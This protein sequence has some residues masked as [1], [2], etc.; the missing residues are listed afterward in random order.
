MECR[1]NCA[2]DRSQGLCCLVAT[3]LWRRLGRTLLDG[4][5]G[6]G[7]AP[8]ELLDGQRLACGTLVARA[9]DEPEARAQ[10]AG[11]RIAGPVP[12]TSGF[13]AGERRQRQFVELATERRL[14]Q[15]Q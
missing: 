6:P 1:G 13:L 15:H 10:V 14:M 4:P 7:N 11:E 2:S 8:A 12:V 9:A 5:N 3:G